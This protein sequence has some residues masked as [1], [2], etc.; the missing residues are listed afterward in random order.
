MFDRILEQSQQQ[1]RRLFYVGGELALE[2]FKLGADNGARVL[3][4]SKDQLAEVKDVAQK[5]WE[6]FLKL[7]RSGLELQMEMVGAAAEL[8]ATQR[9]KTAEA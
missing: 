4:G 5:N 9:K 3:R 8:A 2:G 1:A 7:S 6:Y